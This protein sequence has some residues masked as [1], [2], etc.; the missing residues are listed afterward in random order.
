MVRA[1]VTEYLKE[2]QEPS[3]FNFFTSSTDSDLDKKLVPE[4]LAC[5]PGTT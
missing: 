1:T 5:D 2:N 3:L 4:M